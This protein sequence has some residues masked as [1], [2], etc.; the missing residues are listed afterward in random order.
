M[1]FI[2]KMAI[3]NENGTETILSLIR[4]KKCLSS[5]FRLHSDLLRQA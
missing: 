2:I 1:R 3:E 5:H 4:A